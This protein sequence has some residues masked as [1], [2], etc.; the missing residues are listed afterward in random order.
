MANA[1]REREIDAVA[2]CQVKNSKEKTASEMDTGDSC[3]S[4]QSPR[5]A[6]RPGLCELENEGG[7]VPRLL[8]I[9]RGNCSVCHPL[10]DHS[11]ATLSG[12]QPVISEHPWRGTTSSTHKLG[13]YERS[14]LK[15]VPPVRLHLR[16]QQPWP[17]SMSRENNDR[18][19]LP[20]SGVHSNKCTARHTT[21]LYRNEDPTKVQIGRNHRK[22]GEGW[23]EKGER[24]YR[25]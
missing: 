2:K 23:R 21:R 18:T 4:G 10:W 6:N 5:T 17:V 1:R 12:R 14:I 24:K 13:Q 7:R 16:W 15:M 3:D 25:V 9:G 11:P 20:A 19:H 8:R 22:R